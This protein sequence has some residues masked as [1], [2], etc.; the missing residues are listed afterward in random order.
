M[1]RSAS[2][3]RGHCVMSKS[4]TS[5]FITEDIDDEHSEY[6]MARRQIA[7]AVNTLIEAATTS[8]IDPSEAS[9]IA[10]SIDNISAQLKNRRQLKGV[11]AHANAYGSYPVAN[12]EMLCVGGVSHPMS[13]GLRHWFDG[14]KVYGTVTFNWS[15]EG[16]P[17]HVHGGWVA[18]ILDHF[19]GMAQIHAGNA[20]MTG[21]LDIRYRRPTPL[22]CELDLVASLVP[23]SE[24]KMKVE[25]ELSYEG[26]I[27]AS[28]SAVF[29]K[30]R[31]A[32]FTE[33]VS[34][35]AL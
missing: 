16:P 15:Y 11:I 18:A 32:I 17:N 28:A 21:G 7:I 4:F 3:T 13:P 9:S 29:I 8:D 31:T 26:Q 24:R 27:T 14:D 33:G 35:T 19:M 25:A 22:N 34:T 20:G 5:P 10:D 23:L 2:L 12:H 30:P 6:W 1:A